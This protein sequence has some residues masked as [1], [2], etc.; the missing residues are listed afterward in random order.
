CYCEGFLIQGQYGEA[1]S[2]A[3][4]ALELARQLGARRFQA[5][6]MGM[7]AGAMLGASERDEALR[8]ARE[9]VHI[10][11]EC[12]MSY[13]GPVLLSLVARATDDPAE[14][15]R[16]LEE[17]ESLLAAGCVSHSYFNFYMHAIEVSLEQGHWN[18]ARRYA[19]AL[20]TYTWPEPLPFKKLLVEC[21]SALDVPSDGMQTEFTITAHKDIH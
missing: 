17:G 6:C 8:V 16:A 10:S 12:G 21:A 2:R 20:E 3:L 18:E 4:H 14:R 11:R 7:L 15:I 5:E 1:R 9:S 13:C 19:S